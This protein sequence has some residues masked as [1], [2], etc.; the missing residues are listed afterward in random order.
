V[1]PDGGLLTVSSVETQGSNSLNVVNIYDLKTGRRLNQLNL[2]THASVHLSHDGKYLACLSETG[3]A[4]YT[5]PS[6]DRIGEFKEYFR[7][8]YRALNSAAFAGNSVALPI[9][10]QNRIRLWN[11]TSRQ[12]IALL[13]EPESTQPVAFTEDGNSLL[14]LGERHARVYSLTT[15]EKLDL[16]PHSCAVWA[17]P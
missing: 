7:E 4:T 3:G 11:L 15:P 8:R 9:G 17:W 14:N 2:A 6:L 5:L 16:S 12:D 13:D 10:M 1:T